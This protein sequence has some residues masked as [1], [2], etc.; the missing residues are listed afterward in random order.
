VAFVQLGVPPVRLFSVALEL[1]EH[2]GVDLLELPQPL[3]NPA[4]LGSVRQRFGKLRVHR[5]A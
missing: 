2:A 3:L 4:R 5:P 1:L